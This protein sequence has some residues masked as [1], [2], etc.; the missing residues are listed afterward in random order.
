MTEWRIEDLYDL[1]EC[2]PVRGTRPFPRGLTFD[3]V[4]GTDGV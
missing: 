4:G 1:K 3:F 2:L